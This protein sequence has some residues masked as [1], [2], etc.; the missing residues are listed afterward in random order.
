MQVR[1]RKARKHSS[2][3]FCVPKHCRGSP[4]PK[5]LSK[6][7]VS[8]VYSQCET[9]M[10]AYASTSFSL[11]PDMSLPV[12]TVPAVRDIFSYGMSLCS[13]TCPYRK[14]QTFGPKT[15]L[16]SQRAHGGPGL[17]RR[18]RQV[19]NLE[20]ALA[21]RACLGPSVVASAEAPGSAHPKP[22]TGVAL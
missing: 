17:G 3:G 15:M 19:V 8:R 6:N 13:Y 11:R 20:P 2:F 16:C 22:C 4:V 18:V 5:L 7:A 9:T 14:G 1:V 12:G 10:A 21:R